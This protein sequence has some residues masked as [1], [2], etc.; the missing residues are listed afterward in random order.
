MLVPPIPSVGNANNHANF[1]VGRLGT[2]SDFLSQFM[3]E[4]RDFFNISGS[5]GPP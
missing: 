2:A 4:I 1:G 5:S 3:A